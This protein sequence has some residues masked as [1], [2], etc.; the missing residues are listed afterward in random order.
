[1]RALPGPGHHYPAPNPALQPVPTR[2]LADRKC[3]V[4]RVSSSCSDSPACLLR[5]PPPWPAPRREPT[6][7]GEREEPRE[8]DPRYSLSSSIRAGACVGLGPL[9]SLRH[10]RDTLGPR[11]TQRAGQALIKESQPP[12]LD[13]EQQAQRSHGRNGRAASIAHQRQRNSNDGEDPH[14][15]PNIHENRERNHRDHAGG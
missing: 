3:E 9:R 5:R 11:R 14:G 10:G 2:P 7:T 1:M 12:T 6:K 15:H 13:V 4:S 8:S